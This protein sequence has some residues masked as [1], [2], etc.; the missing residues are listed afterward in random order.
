MS[1]RPQV[2]FIF[3]CQ[4]SPTSRKR[5]RRVSNRMWQSTHA[6]LRSDGRD[7]TDRPGGSLRWPRPAK[8]RK[9]ASAEHGTARE[10]AP[11]RTS[12][13]AQGHAFEMLEKSRPRGTKAYG[14]IARRRNRPERADGMATS[15]E[16]PVA[17]ARTS[18]S[19]CRRTK[20]SSRYATRI[21]FVNRNQNVGSPSSDAI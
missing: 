20:T 10:N 2:N 9:L 16:R 3:K 11:R 21:H 4:P 5:F 6:A 13:D 1:P 8:P 12:F 18:K 19:F 14:P 7:T 17:F 15:A